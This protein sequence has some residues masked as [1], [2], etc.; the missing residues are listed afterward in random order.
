M[1]S[2]TE[3]SVHCAEAL[4]EE[5]HTITLRFLALELGL[6]YGNAHTIVHEELGRS[7]KLARWVPHQLMQKEKR[8]CGVVTGDECLTSFFTME[9]KMQR[10]GVDDRGWATTRGAEDR[11]LLET[12]IV[13]HLLRPILKG[14]L[15]WTSQTKQRSLLNTTPQQ[16]YRRYRSS[17]TPSQQHQLDEGLESSCTMTMHVLVKLAKCRLLLMTMASI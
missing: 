8:F 16:F 15:L 7:R 13:R 14:I 9:Q 2:V 10:Y 17:C 1:S 5:E 11:I 4:I 6:T 12:E 3:T